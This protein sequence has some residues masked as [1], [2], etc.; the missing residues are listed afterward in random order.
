MKA[1]E[2]AVSEIANSSGQVT[3]DLV[4]RYWGF[5]KD[6]RNSRDC[7]RIFARAAQEYKI[8]D[9]F[10]LEHVGMFA[11]LLFTGLVIGMEMEKY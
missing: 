11:S 3:K 6:I 2:E 1:F 7:A 9:E 10:L 4:D 5:M 8:Q